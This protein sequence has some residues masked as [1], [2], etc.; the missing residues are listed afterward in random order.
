VRVDAVDV[1]ALDVA[2]DPR[3]IYDALLERR[4]V[5][6]EQNGGHWLVSRY[7][8][9]QDVA[10]NPRVFSNVGNTVPDMHDPSCPLRPNELDPPLHQ[11][12]RN[13][14]ARAFAKPTIGGL[15]PTVRAVVTELIDGFVD[16]GRCDL[17]QDL[18]HPLPCRV[19]AAIL[20]IPDDDLGRLH[21]A[22]MFTVR[23]FVAKEV[24]AVDLHGYSRALVEARR[25]DPGDGLVGELVR[26]GLDDEELV[27]FFVTLIG[28]GQ[29]TTSAFI[30]HC[31]IQLARDPA[32]RAALVAAPDLLPNA[33]EELLRTE[34]PVHVAVRTV[35]EDVEL[36]G[37]T[38]EA[39]QKVTLMLGAANRD[40]RHFRDPAV[41]DLGRA[42]NHHLAFGFGI[43]RCIGLH[44]ARLET[45][46]ALEEILR[47]VPDYT[48]APEEQ[49]L[50]Y[51]LGGLTRGVWSLPATF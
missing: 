3:A 14:I 49:I 2:T 37:V 26:A 43:H 12:S 47:R 1:C 23:W 34:S 32:Q 19:I 7:E 50:R 4:V 39:G 36:G 29:D 10:R 22:A 17:A 6:S 30:A 40:E 25:D 42:P 11:P 44:L 18:S 35:T 48:I 15:E 13:L 51:N 8:D 20:G 33:I 21:D 46:V 5:W 38:M 41:V 27:G 28:G 45:R 9:V 16:A 31:L 24:G